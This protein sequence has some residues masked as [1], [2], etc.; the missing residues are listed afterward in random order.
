MDEAGHTRCEIGVIWEDALSLAFAKRY[1][2]S[3]RI[4]EVRL[5]GL[6]G[7]PDGIREAPVVDEFKAT[8]KGMKKGPW[9]N[10]VWMMQV[11]SYCTMVS[12]GEVYLEP[13][14]ALPP[15][16]MGDYNVAEFRILHWNGDY[17]RPFQPILAIFHAI[18]GHS[19]SRIR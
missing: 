5:D 19:P 7:S 17:S 2:E 8:S 10:K 14:L 13:G 12:V 9:E 16:T 18:L 15:N 3:T 11:M 4:Y 1:N 6:I